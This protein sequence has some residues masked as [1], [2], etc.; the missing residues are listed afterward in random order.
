[1]QSH[2]HKCNTQDTIHGGATPAALQIQ[3]LT[4]HMHPPPPL[5]RSEPTHTHITFTSLNIDF[6]DR[7][8]TGGR[9]SKNFATAGNA[10]PLVAGLRKPW[11]DQKRSVHASA[12]A[13]I[14]RKS[15]LLR[16]NRRNAVCERRILQEAD[17]SHFDGW[18]R[19]CECVE[20]THVCTAVCL[21]ACVYRA[22]VFI[23][24]SVR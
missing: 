19:V 11:S 13:E 5:G 16:C 12:T 3:S 22:R 7:I 15:A 1:M 14:V 24:H 21:Y 4:P 20:C 6:S 17:G 9:T 18:L 8:C 10:R 2:P 23:E